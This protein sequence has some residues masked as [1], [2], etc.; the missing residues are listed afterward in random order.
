M[1]AIILYVWVCGVTLKKLASTTQRIHATQ[2]IQAELDPEDTPDPVDTCHHH[3]LL[4]GPPNAR[5]QTPTPSRSRAEAGPSRALLL[6][7]ILFLSL[8]RAR[9]EAGPSRA[10]S[11][12]LLLLSFRR[13]RARYPADTHT[14]NMGLLSRWSRTRYPADIPEQAGIIPLG[15]PKR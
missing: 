6:T 2:W 15:A 8:R 14:K 3:Q 4:C 11:L 13:P 12:L 9:A 7:V 10:L 1:L 5:R